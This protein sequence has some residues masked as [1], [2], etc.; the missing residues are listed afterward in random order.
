MKA[1]YIGSLFLY[2]MLSGAPLQQFVMRDVVDDSLPA[3]TTLRVL[4]PAKVPLGDVVLLHGMSSKGS[5]DL[6]IEKLAR[7]IASL[8]FKVWLPQLQEISN[9]EIRRDVQQRLDLLLKGLKQHI[10]GPFAVMAPSY[11]GSIALTLAAQPEHYTSIDVL[12]C[13][14]VFV[15]FNRFMQQVINGQNIDPYGRAIFLK[16]LLIQEGRLSAESH[17]ML[18]RIFQNLHDRRDPM[19]GIDLATLNA[20]DQT[21][22]A[23]FTQPDQWYTIRPQL[24]QLGSLL[25]AP[26][27]RMPATPTKLVFVHGRADTLAVP[28]EI[29]PF[30]CH[31]PKEQWRVAITGLMDHGNYMYKLHQLPELPHLINTFGFFFHHALSA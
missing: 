12:C 8:G 1:F 19:V 21:A 4:M 26:V 23:P 3:E 7:V 16:N 24:Q 18:E 22:L 27:E 17:Q 28:A 31:L 11:L 6:R 15:H 13:I 9:H 2:R 20:T 29:M 5:H 25:Q 10:A 30:V 14:G